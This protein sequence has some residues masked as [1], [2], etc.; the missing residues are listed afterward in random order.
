M[1]IESTLPVPFWWLTMCA[2]VYVQSRMHTCTTEGYQTHYERTTKSPP[3][4]WHLRILGSQ[5][6]IL[7][8]SKNFE[9]KADRGNFIGY[10]EE[11]MGYE[12]L[13]LLRPV[14]W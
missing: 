4:I 6:Y 13:Y 7:K 14:I 9:A 12:M 5:A 11:N 2:A 10:G 1:L 8:R 3:N